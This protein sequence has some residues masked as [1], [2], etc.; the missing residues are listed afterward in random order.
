MTTDTSQI[1]ILTPFYW[2]SELNLYALL[3][4]FSAYKLDVETS[5]IR[6]IF[7]KSINE[8]FTQVS[9]TPDSGMVYKM[10]L[11]RDRKIK[12]GKR[13]ELSDEVAHCGVS[14]N[15]PRDSAAFSVLGEPTKSSSPSQKLRR[16]G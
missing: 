15:T 13:R 6:C 2:P 14:Q 3:G 8:S 10:S 9:E 12:G 1:G 4:N 7:Q 11:L 5:R 16:K